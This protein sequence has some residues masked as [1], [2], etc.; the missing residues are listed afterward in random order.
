VCVVRPHIYQFLSV[1]A[2]EGATAELVCQARGD[3][4][5]QLHFSKFGESEVLRIAENVSLFFD[6]DDLVGQSGC[7]SDISFSCL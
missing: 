7:I 3:P 5:P 6:N 4:L 1:I 2:E